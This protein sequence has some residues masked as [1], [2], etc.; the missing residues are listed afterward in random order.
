MECGQWRSVST[1]NSLAVVIRHSFPPSPFLLQFTLPPTRTSSRLT[2]TEIFN[3]RPRPNE[4]LSAP[5][6]QV[7]FASLIIDPAASFHLATSCPSFLLCN[8]SIF[9]TTTQSALAYYL[10]LIREHL[11]RSIDLTVCVAHR[12]LPSI[13]Q[14]NKH[15]PYCFRQAPS[16]SQ[17]QFEISSLLVSIN[18]PII[19]SS[20]APKLRSRR[21]KPVSCRT[22]FLEC[23]Y[24]FFFMSLCHFTCSSLL[25]LSTVGLGGLL[26]RCCDWMVI[27]HPCLWF[28]GIH[29][30]RFCFLIL[31]AI[32]CR[33]VTVMGMTV[34]PCATLGLEPHRVAA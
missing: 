27:T 25:F 28:L 14:P 26:A 2:S 1:S 16:S 18:L 29:M 21:Y 15:G 33:Y 32:I 3:T 4:A 24:P 6:L 13:T 7:H 8:R 9:I 12:Y 22:S 30:S 31:P 34:F 17:L 10:L 11:Q 19:L 23:R 20:T 5:L